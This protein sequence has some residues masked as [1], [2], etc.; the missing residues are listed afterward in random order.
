MVPNSDNPATLFATSILAR[1]PTELL[2][3]VNRFLP[4]TDGLS[5]METSK[6]FLN[7]LQNEVLQI[8]TL[9]NMKTG[10][11]VFNHLCDFNQLWIRETK[12]AALPAEAM[13]L[14][15]HP[16]E[17]PIVDFKAAVKSLR[18]SNKHCNLSESREPTFARLKL[19]QLQVAPITDVSLTDSWHVPDT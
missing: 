16:Y 13:Y 11:E 19:I 2:F 1:L 10:T 15:F 9:E 14:R 4:Q 3:E 17:E 6:Y 18:T 8:I 5:L 7:A 12:G